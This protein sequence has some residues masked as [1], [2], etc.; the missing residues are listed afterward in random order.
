MTTHALNLNDFLKKYKDA[1][2]R[3][4]EAAII[5]D[6]MQEA[7]NQNKEE[8]LKEIKLDDLATKQDL[9]IELAKLELKIDGKINIAKWQ[10]IG[11]VA[12]MIFIEVVLKHFGF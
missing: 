1:S 12:V 7:K 9:Q 8:L 3:D 6:L 2:G 10:V 5:F 4:E 11:S